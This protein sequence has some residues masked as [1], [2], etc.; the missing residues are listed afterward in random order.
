MLTVDDYQIDTE[1]G[2]EPRLS[3]ET[4]FALDRQKRSFSM[5][6][7]GD[8]SSVDDADCSATSKKCCRDDMKVNLH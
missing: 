3:I 7:T 4:Q 1:E 6:P 8:D 2:T 5:D